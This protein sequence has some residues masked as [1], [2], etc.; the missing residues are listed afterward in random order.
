MSSS[1]NK[2]IV[3][4]QYF[5][6]GVEY[7]IWEIFPKIYRFNA[8]CVRT[9]SILT[10]R[11][12]SSPYFVTTVPCSL[13][14]LGAGSE[15]P[16]GPVSPPGPVVSLL[17]APVLILVDN[18]AVQEPPAPMARGLQPIMWPLCQ[19]PDS[20]LKIRGKPALEG[21]PVLEMYDTWIHQKFYFLLQTVKALKYVKRIL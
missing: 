1:V 21:V 2:L 14:P 12:H 4:G 19:L 3:E 20:L 5:R 6:G 17:V 8:K 15:C 13:S 9:L 10:F 11:C 16:G 7:P 18:E